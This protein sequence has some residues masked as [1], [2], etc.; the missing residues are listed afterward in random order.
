MT[1]VVSDLHGCFEKFNE[2]LK[3]INFNDNDVMYVLGDIVDVGDEPMELLCDI[4][5]RYNVISIVGEHDLKALRLLRAFDR[6]LKEGG[7]ADPE[8]LGEL[9]QWIKEGGARTMEGF[10][11]LDDDMKEGVLEYLEELSLYEEVE[12]RGR[13]YLLVHAGI[14]DFDPDT[15]LEDYMPED[16][17]SE[18]I[19]LERTYF[20]D[21]TVIAGHVPTYTI[22]GADNG[23]IYYGE[24]CIIVDCGAAYGETLGCLCLDNGKEYYV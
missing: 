14:A 16:F 24:N 23:M 10:K 4:S 17:I 22:D 11:A 2:L 6:I 7:G 20:D 8:V 12:V 1:Y 19:D 3:K 18:A 9:T 5:M 15:P 21:V 13:R